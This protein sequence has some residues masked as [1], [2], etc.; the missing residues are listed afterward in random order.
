MHPSMNNFM[1]TGRF[2]QS[3]RLWFSVLA[4]AGLMSALPAVFALAN[5]P[6]K[7]SAGSLSIQLQVAA[8]QHVEHHKINGLWNY[9]DRAQLRPAKLK[10]DFSDSQ[11]YRISDY[12]ALR[13]VFKD[14]KDEKPRPIVFYMTPRRPGEF[15]VIDVD[16]GDDSLLRNLVRDKIAQ[17]V[18]FDVFTSAR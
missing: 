1:K 8:R 9:M 12:Y 3:A 15:V 5:T 14:S 11:I 18:K 7:D 6:V 10:P 2:V 16:A 17:P 13:Y 4:L